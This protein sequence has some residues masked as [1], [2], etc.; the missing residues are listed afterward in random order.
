MSPIQFLHPAASVDI[1]SLKN[2]DDS[3]NDKI[4]RK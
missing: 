4:L 1:E 2:V 3:K